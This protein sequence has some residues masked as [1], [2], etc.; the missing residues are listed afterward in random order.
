[1]VDGFRTKK[2]APA[3][4]NALK[5]ALVYVYWFKPDLRSF[6][7]NSGI[8]PKVLAQLDWTDRKRNIVAGLINYLTKNESAYQR[9]LLDL[10]VEVSRIQ[11]FSHLARLEDGEE[12]SDSARNAVKALRAQVEGLGEIM[13]DEEKLQRRRKERYEQMMRQDA[14]KEALAVL[15]AEFL[16]LVAME[17]HQARG[18]QL[19][20]VLYG[21]FDLFDL[22]PKR[23]FRV[24]GEQI[25]GAFTFEGTDY[26]LEAKWQ[27]KP[28]DA[29]ALDSLAGKLSRKLDNT[30]G[31][32]LSMSGYSPE[33]VKTHSSGRRLMFLMDGGDLNAVLEARIDLIQLLLRKRRAAAQTGNIYVMIH[34]ILTDAV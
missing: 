9:Q 1:M 18:Y 33:A 3:A 27:N 16:A 2:I 34:E 22:D 6:L 30:L 31:V 10:M 26:L 7:S 12:K 5:E 24:A 8:D 25:D 13:A 20:K 32:F 4:I 23:S 21:L 15:T 28:V 19:E 11:D 14:V 29:A 17:D